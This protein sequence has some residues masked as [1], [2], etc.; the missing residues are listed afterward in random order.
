MAEAAHNPKV[1]AEVQ[2]AV[3]SAN[4]SV[5]RAESI[6]KFVILPEDFSEANGTL[7][8]KFSI[9]RNVILEQFE[10]TIEGMYN[11]APVT[12]GIAHV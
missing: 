8:P 12:E 2:K 10:S 5:S 7:T 6:R 4:S 11:N 3:D 1:I 9:K